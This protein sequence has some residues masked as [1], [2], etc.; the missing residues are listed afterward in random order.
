MDDRE[1]FNPFERSRTGGSTVGAGPVGRNWIAAQQLVD[2]RRGIRL[3][4]T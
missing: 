4:D 1:F 2:P 3:S